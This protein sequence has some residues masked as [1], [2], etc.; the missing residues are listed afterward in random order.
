MIHACAMLIVHARIMI[1]LHA[2]TM[3]IVHACATITV[4]AYTRMIVHV[5]ATIV[6]HPSCP[7]RISKQFTSG[8]P[9]IEASPVKREGLGRMPPDDVLVRPIGDCFQYFSKNIMFKASLNT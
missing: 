3:I 5:C 7:T 8:D 4:R 6:I 1:I 2:R 9:E